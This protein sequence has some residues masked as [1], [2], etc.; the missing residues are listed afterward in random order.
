M[1]DCIINTDK[2]TCITQCLGNSGKNIEDKGKSLLKYEKEIVKE[3]INSC[4]YQGTD[5]K[6][7]LKTEFQ[8]KPE[9]KK[10]VIGS[11]KE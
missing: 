3:R 1:K 4:K 6:A 11:I 5:L 2:E 10:Q 8:S 9:N 7:C